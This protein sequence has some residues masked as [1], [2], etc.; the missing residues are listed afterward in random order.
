MFKNTEINKRL[1]RR[2]CSL[3]RELW[4][5]GPKKS[6]KGKITCPGLIIIFFRRICNNYLICNCEKKI[7]LNIAVCF[8]GV[9]A[10]FSYIQNASSKK[11]MFKWWLI[12]FLC[13]L[14]SDHFSHYTLSAGNFLIYFVTLIENPCSFFNISACWVTNLKALWSDSSTIHYTWYAMVFCWCKLSIFPKHSFN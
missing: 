4:K 2:N 9:E 5:V 3:A 6:T 14:E 12:S 11:K 1:I 8:P 13:A 10:K 7:F